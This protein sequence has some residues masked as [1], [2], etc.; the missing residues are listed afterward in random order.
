MGRDMTVP[1]DEGLINIRVGAIILKDGKFLM[2][3]NDRDDYLYS[4]GGRIQYGETSEEAVVR[5]VEEETGV[6]MEVDRLG[7]VSE[8]YFFGNPHTDHR[9]TVYE[10][11]FYYYM[12]VPEDFSPVSEDFLEGESTE[13]LRWVTVHDDIKMFPTF[14]KTELSHPEYVVK[15][16][17]RDDRKSVAGNEEVYLEL[18]DEEWPLEFISHDRRIARGIVFDEDGN[19]YFMRAN[20]DDLFGKVTHI[21]TPGGGVEEGEDLETAVRRELSEELGVEVE[22]ICKLGLVSDYYNVIHRHNLTNYYLC[23]VVSFGEKHLTPA[24]MDEFHLSTLKMRYDDAVA[25]YERNRES[26]IG[27]LIA[28][29]ELPMIKRAKEI[30]DS[31]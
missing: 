28:N 27:R 8:V 11:G 6:K 10:I 12:K 9:R 2:A 26:S 21:E 23:R 30:I 4:V 29:R 31:L 25:E 1:C 13:H 24:E 5:E 22:I 14:F 3:G 7:F 17:V 19:F 15:H 16:F 18:K 20:R